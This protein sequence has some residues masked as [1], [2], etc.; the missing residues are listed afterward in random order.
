MTQTMTGRRERKKAQTRQALAGAAL[1]LF[2]E[3]GFDKV[4]VKEVA[5]AADV[6]LTTLFNHFPSKEALAFEEDKH[7][8]SALV[9]AI[10]N[11]PHGQSVL[12]ALRDHLIHTRTHLRANDPL[13]ALIEATPALRDYAH[14]MWMRHE[15]ALSG[16]I[17]E[18]TGLPAD[19]VAVIGLAR[20]TLDIPA[21]ARRC[22]DPAAAIGELFDLLSHGW[23][24]VGMDGP[25]NDPKPAAG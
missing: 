22:A 2:T 23:S 14:R 7:L 20:F 4:S 17:S 1:R 9:D 18:A 8:E 25:D 13:F 15:K 5:E 16:A 11:R 10:Q 6:S 19:S 3:R 21:V 24:I 12:Q